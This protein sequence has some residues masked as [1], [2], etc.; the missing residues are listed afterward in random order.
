ML[1]SDGYYLDVYSLLKEVIGN[2][3]VE[4]SKF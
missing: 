2:I 1:A 4:N 3:D